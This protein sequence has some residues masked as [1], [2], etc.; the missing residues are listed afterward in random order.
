MK[1]GVHTQPSRERMRFAAPVGSSAR[2]RMQIRRL[3]PSDA[4][5]YMTLRLQ[6]LRD[7]ATA[8]GSSYEEECDTPIDAVAR[9]LATG[10]GR[11]MFGA[12]VEGQLVGMIGVG[13]ESGRKERH[14]V[15]LRSMYVAPAH[16]GKGIGRR[17]VGEAL[18]FAASIPALHHVSLAV[19]AGN[20]EATALYES[21][22]FERTGVAPASLLV[23]GVLYD[24][25]QM[26][27]YV[28]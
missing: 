16:R 2:R 22:G 13:R 5:P 3:T 7:H 27:R 15:S 20:V 4:D 9:L 28:D 8:F 24:E 10:S 25:I 26:V 17:L 19:T 6:A 11:D 23:D 14:K 18:S 21:M 12:F 1:S